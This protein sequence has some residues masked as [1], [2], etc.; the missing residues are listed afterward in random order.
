MLPS[1]TRRDKRPCVCPEVEVTMDDR[2]LLIPSSRVAAQR[3]VKG[4]CLGAEA[5]TGLTLVLPF[6]CYVAD[7]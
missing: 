7:N 4:R 5:V 2:R 6:S 3:W 1:Q